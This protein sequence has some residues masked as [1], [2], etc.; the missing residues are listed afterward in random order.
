MVQRAKSARHAKPGRK[1]L[2]TAAA[3]TGGML[4]AAG[5]GAFDLLDDAL[6]PTNQAAAWTPTLGLAAAVA[7]NPT[8]NPL[9]A[10]A[11]PI[12]APDPGGLGVGGGAAPAPVD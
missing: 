3:V 8:P 11:D 1:T 9:F 12:Q 10:V 4:A 6:D 7:P 5:V 2:V